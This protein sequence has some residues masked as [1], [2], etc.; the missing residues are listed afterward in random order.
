MTRHH[1]ILQAFLLDLMTATSLRVVPGG[2]TGWSIQ[3]GGISYIVLQ[4]NKA[5]QGQTG[6]PHD[7]LADNPFPPTSPLI[8]Q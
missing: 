3:G 7:V 6:M 4:Q 8:M 1:I 2:T 5:F